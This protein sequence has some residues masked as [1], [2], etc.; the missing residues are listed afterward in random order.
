MA[1]VH[2]LA[3][4]CSPSVFDGDRVWSEYYKAYEAYK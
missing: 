4:L 3:A 2:L 1:N